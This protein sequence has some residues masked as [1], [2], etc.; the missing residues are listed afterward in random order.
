MPVL[1]KDL[2]L[3]NSIL[4]WGIKFAEFPM[5]I[6]I[7]GN[8][9]VIEIWYWDWIMEI[10]LLKLILLSQKKFGNIEVNVD[11][12]VKIWKYWKTCGFE[13][14]SGNIEIKPL[15]WKYMTWY[16]IDTV[17]VKK[18]KNY[19]NA[20]GK[21][22]CVIVHPWILPCMTFTEMAFKGHNRHTKSLN[23]Q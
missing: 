23:K 17:I 4:K 22:I 5:I 19:W 15:L 3:L 11:I 18:K 6:V 8:C 14:K 16:W 7:V 12:A 9:I 1:E 13:K 20:N 2:A 21:K 10:A